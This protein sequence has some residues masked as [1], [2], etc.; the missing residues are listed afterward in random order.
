MGKAALSP[1][2]L[3]TSDRERRLWLWTLAAVVAIYATL[4][5]AGGVVDALRERNLLRT[6]FG[7][8]LGVVLAAFIWQW[9]KKR[10]GWS[11]IGVAVGV[12]L[13]Y[14]TAFLRIENPAERTHLIEYGIVAALIHQALL[15][16][17]RNGRS[18]PMPAMIAV[19]A[20]ALLGTV[21]ECIQAVL[22]DRIFDVRDIGFNALAGFMM[23]AARL[24]L[25][26]QRGPGWRLW[27][28]WLIGSAWGWGAG[29]FTRFGQPVGIETLQSS[30]PVLWAGYLG[31]AWGALLVGALQWLLLRRYLTQPS[32]WL[33][34]SAGAAAVTGIVVFGSGAINSVSLDAAWIAGTGLFGSAAGVLQWLVI[35]RQVPRAGWW[36]LASTVGWIV[37]I[38]AGE[39]LGW[40]GLGAVHG[41]ITGSVMVWL[42]RQTHP[43]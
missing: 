1:V 22:P 8:V 31:I 21:D 3:F 37:G 23:I 34:A 43:G 40:N 14:A 18:V 2:S 24:A 6:S 35:K 30:P 16:R 42:L 12:A 27:F 4:G 39:E 26:P 19:G 29:M 7:L 25:A 13:V 32:H 11:E 41:L 38:P 20:T 17:A 15:E 28:W 9:A 5:A 33:L 10:P 36:V